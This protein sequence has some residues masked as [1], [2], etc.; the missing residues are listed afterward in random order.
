MLCIYYFA[1]PPCFGSDNS[2]QLV[3][4][5]VVY[6]PGFTLMFKLLNEASRMVAHFTARSLFPSENSLKEE[7]LIVCSIN[8]GNYNNT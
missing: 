4:S 1:K 7:I 6:M 8:Y 5:I 3:S 2:T